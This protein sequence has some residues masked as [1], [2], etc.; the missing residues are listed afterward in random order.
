MDSLFLE[1]TD[2]PSIWHAFPNGHHGL[3]RLTARSAIAKL[4]GNEDTSADTIDYAFDAHRWPALAVASG[5]LVVMDALQAWCEGDGVAREDWRRTRWDW[6]PHYLFGIWRGGPLQLELACCMTSGDHALVRIRAQN[7]GN[8]VYDG[9]M[10]ICGDDNNTN[11]G[12]HNQRCGLTE[13]R[14]RGESNCQ[15][16]GD[17]TVVAHKRASRCLWF[18]LLP[19]RLLR[20]EDFDQAQ[21]AIPVEALLRFGLDSGWTTTLTDGTCGQYWQA[22]QALKLAPGEAREFLIRFKGRAL[23]AEAAAPADFSAVA[24]A[25][26]P[27]VDWLAAVAAGEMTWRSLLGKVPPPPTDLKPEWQRHYYKAWTVPFYNLMPPCDL[28]HVR[29]EYPTVMCNRVA[30]GGFTVPASW[31][32]A[33][34]ALLVGMVDPDTGAAVIEGIYST[35]EDDGFIAE[36]I[37]G[38]R[39]TQLA[40]IEPAIAWMLYKLGAKREFLTRCFDRMWRNHLYRHYHANW[41]HLTPLFCRNLIY[42][43]HAAHYLGQIAALLGRP[44]A[45]RDRLADMAVDCERAVAAAWTEEG[46]YYRDEYDPTARVFSSVT[47][48]DTLLALAGIA[49]SGPQERLLEQLPRHFLAANGAIRAFAPSLP[50]KPFNAKIG[51]SILKCSNYL[52]LMPAL[53]RLVPELFSRIHDGTLDVIHREG[54]FWEQ[55]RLQGHGFN[56]GPGSVFGAFGFIWT[57]LSMDGTAGKILAEQPLPEHHK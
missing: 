22:R 32:A 45:E 36:M 28:G 9:H 12:Q 47:Q 51:E 35:M 4:T 43:Y 40:N 14:W 38:T 23:G 53:G 27:S 21:T 11:I 1:Q 7:V 55:N 17:G 33:L 44:A 46:G 6:H 52:Y 37:G 5:A 24:D 18:E 34:G 20:P 15:L 42:N 30:E 54:D 3:G 10:V 29:L 19:D 13:T 57:V 39:H 49:R 2:D 48:A 31:E 41:R 56:N 50:S 25:D 16:R 8:A 26:D